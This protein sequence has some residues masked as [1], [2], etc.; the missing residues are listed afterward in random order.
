MRDH[1]AKLGEEIRQLDSRLAA[2]ERLLQVDW[3]ASFQQLPAEHAHGADEGHSRAPT[4][5][6]RED[7]RQGLNR[8]F[9]GN[10]S[11]AALTLANWN[12]TLRDAGRNL[13]SKL[14]S[15]CKA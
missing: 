10:D 8:W 3:T 2:T 12:P 14:E 9:S 6:V 5:Q 15:V 1:Q 4:A 7:M 13:S 11:L